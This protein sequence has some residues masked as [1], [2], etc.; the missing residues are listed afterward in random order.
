M[1]RKGNQNSMDQSDIKYILELLNDAISEK[2]W[3]KIEEVR[4][5]VKEFLDG[6]ESSEDEQKI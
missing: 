4:E 1:R 6:D 3:D 5:V 2:D